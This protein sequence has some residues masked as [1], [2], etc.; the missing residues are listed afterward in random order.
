MLKKL[1]LRVGNNYQFRCNVHSQI[2]LD[3]RIPTTLHK[4]NENNFLLDVLKLQ[5]KNSIEFD[6][7]LSENN[8]VEHFQCKDIDSDELMRRLRDE[9]KNLSTSYT[10]HVQLKQIENSILERCDPVNLVSSDELDQYFRW[11]VMFQAKNRNTR[12]FCSLLWHQC[13]QTKYYL[14]NKQRFL[15]TCFLLNLFRQQPPSNFKIVAEQHAQ[16]LLCTNQLHVH[17][18]AL[19]ASAFFKTQT[20][21]SSK[22]VF[23]LIYFVLDHRDELTN[24]IAAAC[25]LKGIRYCDQMSA[26]KLLRRFIHEFTD[27]LPNFDFKVGI[28][29]QLVAKH[30]KC[31]NLELQQHLIRSLMEQPAEQ[32]RIKDIDR[33]LRSFIFFNKPFDDEF[34]NFTENFL[35]M[36]QE[37]AIAFPFSGVTCLTDLMFHDR[38]PTDLIQFVF[39]HLWDQIKSK[40]RN[41]IYNYLNLSLSRSSFFLQKTTKKCGSTSK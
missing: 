31:F 21:M 6:I 5:Q 29:L 34:L 19:V 8:V 32:I 30:H 18:A 16:R 28:Q 1:C 25:I 12:R 36:N 7:V 4:N 38:F 24:S 10:D 11:L 39:D 15:N 33:L 35:R 2:R 13:L 9:K 14:G 22:T 26:H 40:L 23:A 3:K 27:L 20:K 37:Q 17:E 41:G